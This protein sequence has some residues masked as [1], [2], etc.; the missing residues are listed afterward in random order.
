MSNVQITPAH[1]A[2]KA[3]I[4]IRQSSPGQVLHNKESQRLQYGLAERAVNLGWPRSQVMVIDEDL[5]VSGRGGGITR[6]GFDRLVAEVELGH[7]GIVVSIEVSRMA[8]NNSD[9]YHL[10][11][12]C[13]LVD[14][15]GV[16]G[17]CASVCSKCRQAAAPLA[18]K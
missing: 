15:L 4:Y 3:A 6:I 16:S 12:L 18:H 10:L 2:R 13:A 9:W 17:L 1:L 8:R 11:D 7:I 5:G 14:T